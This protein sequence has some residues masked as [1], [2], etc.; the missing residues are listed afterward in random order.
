[1]AIDMAALGCDLVTLSAHKLGGPAGVGALVIA[2][3]LELAARVHGGG[4]ERGRRAGT[5][6]LAGIAGFGAVAGLAEGDLAAAPGLAALRDG[7]ERRIA[8]LAGDDAA[9]HGARE[10]RVANTSSLS[11]AG[12]RRRDPSDRIRP[13]RHRRQRRRRLPP[14]ARWRART[15][16]RR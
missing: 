2:P 13:G 7:L 3:D 12:V 1:M 4:Q 8:E 16:S 5:E 15:C 9:F 6:N 11:M 10:R 14:R